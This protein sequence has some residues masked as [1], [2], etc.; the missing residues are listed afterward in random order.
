MPEVQRINGLRVIR[1][2]LE[3]LRKYDAQQIQD[4]YYI[5]RLDSV[6]KVRIDLSDIKRMKEQVRK[7]SSDENTNT[8]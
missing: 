4:G 1:A 2:P 8:D 3:D 6:E 5:H 7:N